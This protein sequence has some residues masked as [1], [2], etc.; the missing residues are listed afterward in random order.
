MRSNI[1]AHAEKAI[2]KGW[3][4]SLVINCPGSDARRDRERRK[5]DTNPDLQAR[6]ATAHARTQ[7]AVAEVL[8]RHGLTP[9]AMRGGAAFDV[10]R[11][12]NGV[13][14]IVEVKSLTRRS[15]PRQAHHPDR[16]AAGPALRRAP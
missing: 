9:I 5:F 6:G 7:N 11:E 1:K 14:H 10:G 4:G 16:S 12:W 3:P 8:E 2:A 13:L 15:P